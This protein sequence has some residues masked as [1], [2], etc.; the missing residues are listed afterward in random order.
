M[1]E[2]KIKKNIIISLF[3]LSFASL[4]AIA[5]ES[6]SLLVPASSVQIH[7]SK[8][9]T[10][11]FNLANIVDGLLNNEKINNETK[12][13]EDNI[14][15]RKTQA[16]KEFIQ[17]TSK[18]NQ[19]NASVAYDEYE[20][21][22]LHIEEDTS[23]LALAKVFYEIGFFSLANN[24]IDKIVYKNQFYDNIS[25]FENSYIPKTALNKEE[26]IYFAK[27]YSSIY[28]D[29]SALES[30]N[31]L[32]SK[33]AQYQKNDYYN[34]MLSRAYFESKKYNDALN[35][36]NKAISIAPDNYQ[37]QVFKIDV[38][39]N[40]KRYNDALKIIQ[41]FEKLPL[42]INF[43]QTI[44]IKK[45]YIL[46]QST[47]NDKVK[48]YHTVQKTFL[49]GNYEKVK[50]DCQNILN[51]DKDNAQ[52]ITMYAKSE[53]ALSNVERAN[54]YFVNSYKIDKN[55]P[56]TIIGIGDIKYLHGDYKNA[57]KMYKK[58]YS[59]DKNNYEIILKLSNA[60]R[61]YGKYPKELKKLELKLDKMPKNSYL[62]YY[63]AA[64]SIAQK[65]DV[66]KEDY[67]KRAL[68][69]NPMHENSLGALVELYLKNKNFELAKSLISA[70]SLTL[71]KNYYYYYL[72]GLYNQ[73]LNKKNEAIQFY[74][75]S[76]NL[77]PSFEIANVKLLKL[78]PDTTDEEI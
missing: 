65:N 7:N 55:N 68:M 5:N 9:S 32:V 78:I 2:K 58:A 14:S 75:T 12:V 41:K 52:I 67:L 35:Y 13:V 31:E 51:F 29:N 39:T 15:D 46:A 57:V 70:T 76:L 44:K 37:Y 30:I 36:I 4:S 28:F 71:E 60:Q 69:I 33:K 53:L 26:E 49:E 25:D 19:G 45:E 11:Y 21:L 22:I 73:A 77:N 24:A 56:E 16:R 72:C 6:D 34:F 38:L 17:I 59:N 62:D 47:K 40:L 64:I 42:N 48:K 50:K 27:I 10:N 20:K 43:A 8:P 23:L 3:F 63:S 66:L 1:S 61:Q 54:T 18:F 74:K